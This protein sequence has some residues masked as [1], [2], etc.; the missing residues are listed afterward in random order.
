MEKLEQNFS[1]DLD[2]DLNQDHKNNSR[3]IT[4]AQQGIHENLEKVVRKHCGNTYR[5]PIAEHTL[6]AFSKIQQQ[7]EDALA[8]GTPL[9]MD[10]FCGTAVSTR[11]IAKQ[12]PD[13]LVI[14]IDRSEVRLSKQY[15]D[16]VPEN[17]ILV[18][19]D[20][21]DFWMLAQRAGWKTVKHTI[22]YPN[23]YPKS[24]HL[25]RRWHAHPAY[26]SLLALGGEVELRTNWKVYADEFCQALA[27]SG[28]E[29]VKSSGVEVIDVGESFKPLTLFEKKYKEAGQDLYRCKYVL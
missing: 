15:D 21:A 10:S 12:N 29:G 23:P 18:Q 2:Q 8:K 1:Q 5:K 11:I 24:K 4:D 25:K 17:A 16:S 14:G 3:A 13:A 19:A 7:V 27:Y 22:L 28:L 9:L 20:C 6:D 26:P